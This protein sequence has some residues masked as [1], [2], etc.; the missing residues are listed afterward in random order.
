VDRDQ[1]V[2]IVPPFAAWREFGF[3]ELDIGSRSPDGA[4][5]EEKE[6]SSDAPAAA[7]VRL[8][9]Y[10]CVS[11]AKAAIDFYKKA[12][13]ARETP[14]REMRKDGKIAYAE[15]MIGDALIM[16]CDESPEH[17]ARSAETLGGSPVMLVLM[18]DDARGVSRRAV[19]AGAKM[20]RDFAQDTFEV[21]GGEAGAGAAVGGDQR[22]A[23]AS[24]NHAQ[25]QDPF[26]QKW[27][28]STVANVEAIEAFRRIGV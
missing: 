27:D 16:I 3:D 18:V 28:V 19:D 12:F 20:V 8:I 6:M 14:I 1:P 15:I 21:K 22:L 24:H 4:H 7:R 5:A 23:A 25:L 9:P 2:C 26:G 13:G 17:G 11:D 10:V